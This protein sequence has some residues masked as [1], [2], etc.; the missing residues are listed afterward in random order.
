MLIMVSHKFILTITIGLLFIFALYSVSAFKIDIP[1]PAFNNNTASV[2]NTNLFSGYSVSAL[3]NYYKGLF[4]SI[5][6]PLNS[7]PAGY[8]NASTLPDGG[9][10]SFN[11]TLTDATYLK[12]NQSG[13]AQT[14]FGGQPNFA[15]GITT[16]NINFPSAG[17]AKIQSTGISRICLYENKLL[18]NG[19]KGVVDWGNQLLKDKTEVTT[20]DWQNRIL[21][22]SWEVQD[23]NVTGLVYGD[24]SQ[25]TGIP[26][27]D[28]SG[29]FTLNQS[30]PQTITGGMPTFSGGLLAGDKIMFTQ[31]DGNEYIDS[32]NDSYIDYVATTAHRFNT[33]VGIGS[34]FTNGLPSNNLHIRASIVL[35]TPLLYLEQAGTG[36]SA[37][38]FGISSN[39][40]AMGIDNSDSDTFKI[41]YGSSSDTATL[42]TN[43]YVTLDTAGTLR[44]PA[45][46][47]FIKMGAET[48][49][50]AN[51]EIGH[52][53][54]YSNFI[55]G[56]SGT[57][58][59]FGRTSTTD[60]IEIRNGLVY[61]RINNNWAY[62][63]SATTFSPYTD[64]NGDLGTSSKEWG[65]L[66][67][68]EIAYIDDIRQ[69]DNEGHY[70]GTGN[71]ASITYDGTNMIFNTSRVGSGLAYFSNNVSA[72]GFITRT[73][74]FDKS[75][76]SALDLIKDASELRDGKGDIDHTKF[77]GYTQ[78]EVTDFSKPES[79]EVC[80]DIEDAEGKISRQCRNDVTYPHK[81]NESGVNIVDEIEL[82]R[83]ALVEQKII[84]TNL[85]AQNTLIKD[86]TATS[87]DF[88]TYKECLAK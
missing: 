6:Y 11:Q 68:D 81:K 9:N 73:S 83:Q 13:G 42:G 12:L 3:Y 77:Y 84:N 62:D 51:L 88:K 18:Y 82:L 38:R 31:T 79:K 58:S 15:E 53:G 19:D 55:G 33:R 43:D 76:G 40:F 37:L 65:Q 74:T 23:L 44:L 57:G 29:Y 56:Y 59:R 71:D 70:W 24:G 60:F 85:Q 45:D 39:S 54:T 26:S 41:S 10:S 4:D 86:C 7:N 5:Y 25:L 50:E 16:G 75:K 67:I 80:E 36:D 28:L 2:N 34:G 35:T 21:N 47:R 49:S 17:S 69:N 22:G 52:T 14:V 72:T 27:P 61:W 1:L 48:A 46:N 66:F 20:L 78:F 63:L 32:L 30:T 64:S 87:L 8:Y